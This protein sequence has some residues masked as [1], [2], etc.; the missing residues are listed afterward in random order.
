MPQIPVLS[1]AKLPVASRTINFL[2][3]QYAAFSKPTKLDM[4]NN[5]GYGSSFD[6]I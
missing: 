2:C 6:F 5:T 4:K 1:L 3:R